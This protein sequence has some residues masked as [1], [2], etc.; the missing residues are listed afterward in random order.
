MRRLLSNTLTRLATWLRPKR[1]PGALAS[2]GFGGGFIDAFQRQRE[3]SAHELLVEL[4][5]T[6]WAC[7]SINAAVCASHPPRLF[8]RTAAGQTPFKGLTRPVA[9]GKASGIRSQ[10]SAE[11]IEEVLDHPLLTLL[12]QV[13]EVH[14]GFDLWEMTQLYLEVHGCAYWLVEDND[15]LGIP[16]AIYVLPSQHVSLR[17]EPGSR[18]LVDAYEYRGGGSLVR[19]RPNE[20]IHFRFPDPR[21]PYTR[22]LSP[23]RACYEQVALTSEYSALKRSLYANSGIPSVIVSPAVV[24]GDEERT[25]LEEQWNQRFRRGGMGKV[26]VAESGLKVDLLQPSLGDLAALADLKATKEDIANCFHVPLPFLSGDTNLANMQAAD[27]LHKTL[28]I[29]PRLTRRD[30]KL[31]EQLIPRYDPSG[32]LFVASDDPVPQD[33]LRLLRQQ[34]SD[35]KHGVRTINEIRGE[36]GLAPVPWGDR[37]FAG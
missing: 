15:A 19:Y 23:L 36:R 2:G 27:H 4:K 9:L 12:R 29:R 7:A 10:G 1:F 3:P 28:A 17:R 14:N 5:G 26:L 31:N 25:R 34:E 33:H 11:T 32:R 20:I 37:P 6:A 16:E 35:L 22:G 18:N 24:I 13:N 21:D 30:E 8:V